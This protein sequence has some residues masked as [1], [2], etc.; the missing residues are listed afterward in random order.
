MALKTVD[1]KPRIGTEVLTDIDTLLSGQHA[2]ELR[3]LLEQ[4]SIL[5]FRRI[6]MSQE[7]HLAFSR[8]LGT[9]VADGDSKA[10]L[11]DGIANVSM[12]KRVMPIADYFKASFFWHFDGSVNEIPPR[13]SL[14]T[15]R[16]LSQTGGGVTEF[17][18][19]YAAY[20]DLPADEKE[21]YDKVRV[22][23]SLE[24]NQR[25]V[26]PMPSYATL[27]E[28][29]RMSPHPRSHP[30]VWHH[31]SGRNSL[32]VGAT[33]SH[34]DGWA[35]EDGRGVLARLLD[36]TTQPQYVYS[37]TW[38]VGDMI[39]YDNSGA[40]HRVSPYDEASGRLMQRT[41]LVGEEQFI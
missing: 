7:Q 10:G 22:I 25:V 3:D 23:H 35:L 38:E 34:I 13:A 40:L 18:N 33:A 19:T 15:A 21:A 8:T 4:R 11:K 12:D 30:L 41:T 20:E 6:N 17:A 2:A 37:H 27:L 39:V 9:V 26:D 1:L 5:L 36:W 14:L 16:A 32:V 28:W 31:A 24:A 29:R